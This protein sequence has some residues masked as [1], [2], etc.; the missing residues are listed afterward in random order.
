MKLKYSEITDEVIQFLER[1]PNVVVYLELEHINTLGEG[2][3]VFASFYTRK[4]K[5]SVIPGSKI[6]RFGYSIITNKSEHRFGVFFLDGF[7]DGISI[8]SRGNVQM[9]EIICFV[10][11]YF[12]SYPCKDE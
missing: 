3:A 5:N 4:I 2:R 6:Y 7:G 1:T 8:E 10:I 9:S 11:L 12:A